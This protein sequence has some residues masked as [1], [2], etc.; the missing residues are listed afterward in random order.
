MRLKSSCL[1]LG[2]VT[3]GSDACLWHLRVPQLYPDQ[4]EIAKSWL[5]RIGEEVKELEKNGRAFR[6]VNEIL[7]LGKDKEIVWSV[8]HLWDEKLR[9]AKILAGESD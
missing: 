8:D 3:H 7:R 5:K 6:S 9:L 2:Y 1:L 4:V